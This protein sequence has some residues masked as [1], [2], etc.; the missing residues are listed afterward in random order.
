MFDVV[1]VDLSL[2][3]ADTL[4]WLSMCDC[5]V[6]LLRKD[7]SLMSSTQFVDKQCFD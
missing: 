1:A 2:L 3:A 5:N 6:V 4:R 7:Q